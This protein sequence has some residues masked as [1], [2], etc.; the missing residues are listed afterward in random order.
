MSAFNFHFNILLFEKYIFN[1][2][3][4]AHLYTK[5]SPNNLSGFPSLLF[6]QITSKSVQQFLVFYSERLKNPWWSVT[7]NKMDF[8][9]ILPFNFFKK[10]NFVSFKRFLAGSPL[11]PY[12]LRYLLC[13]CSLESSCTLDKLLSS[14]PA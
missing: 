12:A 6:I 10:C 5:T 2:Y 7:F 9:I 13:W 11:P 1:T 3:V 14:I 8:F 4:Q